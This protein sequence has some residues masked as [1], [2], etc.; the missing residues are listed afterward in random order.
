MNV[1][2]LTLFTLSAALVSAATAV[3]AEEP[4]DINALSKSDLA[5]ILGT[6]DIQDG[7][8]RKH[9]RVVLKQ[10]YTIGGYQIE[11]DPKCEK[12]FPVMADISAWRLMEDWVIVL[13]DPLRKERI[14]FYTPDNTYVAEPETDGISTIVKLTR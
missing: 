3:H 7:T 12:V 10:D 1:R 2:S 5:G 8:G 9:C 14:R 13:A 6:Y 11:V 4:I